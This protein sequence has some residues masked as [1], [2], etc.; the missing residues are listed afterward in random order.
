MSR[1]GNAVSITNRRTLSGID[2]AAPGGLD[3]L[4]AWSR[5]RFGDLRM[6][7]TVT[8]PA[9]PAPVPAP[10]PKPADP[11]PEPERPK[12]EDDGRA[13]ALAEERR[14]AKAAE[15]RA[16]ALEA[17]VKEFE[18]AKLSEQE[19][20]AKDLADAKAAADEAKA[21]AA[22]FQLDALKHRV[23]AEKG[24]PAALLT[25]TDEESL[26]AS[27]DAALSWRGTVTP[28]PQKAPKPDPSVGPRGDQVVSGA[29]LYRAK[30]PKSPTPA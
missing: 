7:A 24:V 28:E 23:A 4:F 16:K 8:A 14:R 27:A 20:A 22:R 30:H 13:K 18:D 15:D 1:E 9:E 5:N 2:L 3:A 11:A 26:A 25:G 12:P 29:D 19:R 6:D 17:K 21:E 10:E